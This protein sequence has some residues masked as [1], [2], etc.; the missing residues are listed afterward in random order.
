MIGIGTSPMITHPPSLLDLILTH[1]QKADI[2][3]LLVFNRL[4]RSQGLVQSTAWAYP[5]PQN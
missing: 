3:K 1:A 4:R 2:V 5:G